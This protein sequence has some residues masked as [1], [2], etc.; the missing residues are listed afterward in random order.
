MRVLSKKRVGKV[1][2][3]V[4]DFLKSRIETE[5]D[6][7]NFIKLYARNKSVEKE[8]SY[9][10]AKLNGE[11]YEYKAKVRGQKLIINKNDNSRNFVIKS[12][13]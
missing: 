4:N 5:V 2:E 13:R 11:V 6:T 3:E 10:V 8:N 1:D 9:L 7:S 12:W